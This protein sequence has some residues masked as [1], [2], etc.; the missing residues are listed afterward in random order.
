MSSRVIRRAFTLVEL[1]VVIGIIALLISILLPALNKAKE[2]ANLIECQSNLRNIG[3]MIAEYVAENNGYLPYGYATMHGGYSNL[4]GQAD[5]I[6]NTTCWQWPDTLTR[7]TSNLTPGVGTIPVYGFGQAKYEGNM[8]ADF[9]GVFHDTDTTGMPYSTRVSDYFANPAVLIDTNMP[10]PRAVS[11]GKVT[12][13]PGSATPGFGYMALRQAGSIS[14]SAETMVAWCGP[15]VTQDGITITQTNG[16]GAL[17][18]QLDGAEI[19]WGT[20]NGQATYGSYYPSPAGTTYTQ[21]QYA[22]PIA[23]GNP[24]PVYG[25]SGLNIMNVSH[26]NNPTVVPPVLLYTVQQENVDDT[27]PGDNYASFCAMRFRHLDNTTTAILFLDGHADTRTL[28]SVVA[29]DICVTTTTGYGN[30]PG[31]G[32]STANGP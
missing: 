18:E 2:Q 24:D 14:R 31:L 25:G 4:N 9:S 23:I 13:L 21:S 22:K 12:D 28:F 10:D 11:A 3:Q 5:N 15:Q 32:E 7:M 30:G 26:R 17:A 29:R 6:G 1:L 27:N 8:A 16:Y 20:P 19:E